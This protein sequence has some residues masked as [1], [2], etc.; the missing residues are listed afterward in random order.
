MET[1][2]KKQLVLNFNQ[3]DKNDIA[4]VGGK[5]ANLGEMIQAGFP[6]PPG[7]CLTS[8]S[9]QLILQEND[10]I[11]LIKKALNKLNIHKA[12]DL[13]RVAL[14]IQNLI[15]KADIPEQIL[16]STFRFYRSLQKNNPNPLVAV[17][18]SATAEDLPDASFAGQQE[19]YLNIKGEANLIQAIRHAYA[20]LF[21]ARAIFY[22]Q[23]KGFDHFSVSLA[24][25][26][27]LMI[28]SEISGVMFSINPITNNKL[29]LVIE[30][31]FGLGDYVVQG[32][33]TPD[34]YIVNK[35]NLTIHSRQIVTQDIQEKYNYPNG[36]KKTKVP[37]KLQNKQKLSDNQILKL[38]QIGIQIHKHYYFPQDMEWAFAD[39]QL[40]IVQSRPITTIKKT[41]SINQT[42]V[43]NLGSL[44]QIL[45][46]QPASVGI[47]TGKVIKIKNSKELN[48]VKSGNILVTSMTSP[49]FVPAM[50]RA[51]G[52][53][54]DKG[55]QT[56]HAAI[57]SRELGVPAIVGTKTATK[58]LKNNQLISLNGT[59]GEIYSGVPEHTPVSSHL[60]Q[61]SAQPPITATKIYVN[62]G[63]PDLAPIIAQKNADGVGLL[64]AEFMIAQ[65]GI[66]PKLIIQNKQQDKF[67]NQ[68]A[69]NLT[70]F[71]QS[72]GNRPVIY[73]AT[74]F[75]TNEYRNLKGGDRFEPQENNPMLGFRGAFRYI[76]DKRVFQMELSAIK[77]VRLAGFNNLHLMIPF[78]RTVSELRQTKQI[79]TE[80]GLSRSNNFKLFMMAEVPSNFILL[81]DFIK[82]GIDGVSIGSNDL[83]MLILGTDRD[84][85][86]MASVYDERNPAVLF[87]LEHIIKT[88]KKHN[89]LCSICGQAPSFYS[90]LTQKLV[91]WGISSI[92][93]SPDAIDRTRQIVYQAEKRLF[94]K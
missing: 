81:E 39:D 18:S 93:V 85:E 46:G 86:N 41:S 80:F 75:K 11:P 7:F 51:A 66:H 74:D 61:T 32:V 90:D 12:K 94:N 56:S 20:S 68:L 76:S 77:K 62:L 25:P 87:A 67:I 28:Q 88:C 4:L 52:I 45:S 3:I 59:T 92:S 89:I 38:A 83:T 23:T 35:D 69:Q 6:V 36:V 31:A 16:K 27:Q 15:K 21:S 29:Q 91:G 34:T 72:F 26:I 57:V 53:I 64:R 55:G 71:A 82:V 50:K 9:Y 40:Y 79:I 58:I 70:I 14:H 13:S 44:P 47:A 65:I 73:R 5:A 1:D 17:R 22:R 33:I 63:E 48:K 49:D 2:R 37:I 24:I 54:T 43:K 8:Y 60:V 30:A 42:F 78:V 10:L 19:S 84:N